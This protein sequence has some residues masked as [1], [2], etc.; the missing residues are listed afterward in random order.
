MSKILDD[1]LKQLE[2]ARVT[3]DNRP[4]YFQLA[5]EMGIDYTPIPTT[6]DIETETEQFA[7]QHPYQASLKSG[8]G[9]I[10]QGGTR[11]FADFLDILGADESSDKVK[12][13]SDVLKTNL[14]EMAAYKEGDE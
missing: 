3:I 9:A 7:Q 4:S 5:D 2:K 13:V 14:D 8:F 6:L 12:A 11:S 1:Y 10:A